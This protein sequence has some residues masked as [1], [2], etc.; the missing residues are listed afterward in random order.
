MIS[1]KIERNATGNICG[2]EVSNH[3]GNEVCAA[4]SLLTLNT[5]NSVEALLDNEPFN[6]DYDPEGGYLRLELP[7]VKDNKN[8][9][10]V[11]LLM[12]SMLLG[13]MSVKENYS[14]EIEIE[15]DKND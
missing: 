6:C 12:E 14:D 13:L 2:Y 15:D 9:K 4:V 8:C 11:N 1:V 7:L 3:G 10:D 5:A